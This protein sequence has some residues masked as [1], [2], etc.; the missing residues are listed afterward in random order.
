[1]N[2]L[3]FAATSST[4]SINKKLLEY[5]TRVLETDLGDQVEFNNLD[6]NDLE[7]PIYSVDRETEGGVPQQAKDF[8]AA[9]GAADAIVISFAEHNG[10]Y[11]AAYKNLFDWASRIDM[12][13]Y[14]DTPTVMLSTSVGGGGGANVL[15]TAVGSAGFFGNEVLASLAVPSFGENFD[16]ETGTITDPELDAEFRAALAMITGLANGTEGNRAA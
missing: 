5:A 4:Q 1:M 8:F 3:T 14:Q 10:L 6:L 9:I 15:K 11:T 13:V 7:M 12:R 16:Q 2:I